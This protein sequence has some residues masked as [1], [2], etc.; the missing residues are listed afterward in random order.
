[1][2]PYEFPV[3]DIM[4]LSWNEDV[5]ERVA[6]GQVIRRLD[7]RRNASGGILLA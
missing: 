1:M 2:S 4:L 6:I 5:A 3:D 7:V